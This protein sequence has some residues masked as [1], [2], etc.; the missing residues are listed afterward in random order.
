MSTLRG[1]NQKGQSLI[2]II[3][4][5]AIFGIIS[6]AMVSMAVGGVNVVEQ[7][8]EQMEAQA[9]AE[10]GLEAVRSIR[11]RAWNESIYAQSGVSVSG[12]DWVFDGEATTDVTGQFT[13]TIS[14]ADVC[15]DGS[16]NVATCPASYT[17]A[18]TQQVTSRVAWT[19]GT[20]SANTVERIGLLTNWDS[21]D[22]EQSDWVGGSGQATWSDVTKYASRDA[23]DYAYIATAGE[24][25]IISGD[26]TDDSF[27]ISGDSSYD[28]PFST[29]GNYTYDDEKITVTGA[30][31]QLVGTGAEVTTGG[32]L[33]PDFDTNTANWAYSDWQQGGGIDVTGTR[34]ESGG[35]PDGYV[36]VNIPG[37]K[38]DTSSGYWEQ[39]FTTTEDNP[40]ISSVTFDWIV[41]AYSAVLLN[42][43]QLYVFVDSSSGAPT[44]GTEVW[45]SG[46]ITS[47]TTWAS[48]SAVDLTSKI[49][50]QGAYYLKIAV[51]R[52]TN[53][54]AGSPGTNTAGFDNVDLDWEYTAPASYPTD[55]PSIYPTAS[56]SVPGVT[57]W[58]SFAETAEKDGGEIYYQISNNNGSTWKYWT[59]SAWATAVGATD[60]NLATVINTNIPTFTIV[61]AQITFRAFLESD[62]AQLVQLDNVN[63]GFNGAGSVWNFA[64]WDVDGGEVTPSGTH[65]STGGNTGGYSNIT[66]PRGGGDEVGGYWEQ[67]FTTYRDNPTGDTIDFDYKIVD[68]NDTPNV[69]HIRVYV[70]TAS[71]TPTTQVGS[72]IVFSAEG[73]WTSATQIDPSS[74]IT[75][76]GVYY[77]KV[78]VWV[79]TP[80]G[81]G[82]NATGPFQVGFDNV[83]IDLGNGEHP[84]TAQLT[85]SDF[86]T[87]AVSKIQAINWSETIPGAPY[88]IQFQIKTATT[89]GGLAT[90]EWA[91]PEGKDGDETDYFT[92]GDGTLIH[93]DH[94]SDQWIRYRVDFSGDGDDTPTLSDV[95]VNY[96]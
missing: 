64:S 48:Q 43:F 20:G 15:R 89:Q 76:A 58:A 47:T 10:E 55:V 22:W 78:A 63:V 74:A 81:G 96:K 29:A 26:T 1:A 3:V 80:A 71:G 67:S 90:A 30:F 94:N 14:F 92:T 27:A 45:S 39:E 5:M 72:S 8:A 23:N 53:G 54:G 51:R 83:N 69:A 42:S 66:V 17:D 62:G 70:D 7:G 35:N 9:F 75:T 38:S 87:S 79:E 32:T 49:G 84:E 82:V 13:R 56:A 68:F 28:W 93:T 4:A 88:D 25:T 40:Q 73:D 33:N 57:S 6:A 36:Q 60:Y 46:E 50:L 18:H 21:R 59:G 11:D 86:D 61:N 52:K 65:K 44:L 24:V 85:S 19:T 31:A 12:G 95:Q 2:E 34:V 91:G 37:K 77:L 41:T 16:D